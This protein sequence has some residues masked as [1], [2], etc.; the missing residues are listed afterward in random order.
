MTGTKGVVR[1]LTGVEPHVLV[2]KPGEWSAA[3]RSDR[4]EPLDGKPGAD[5]EFGPANQRLVDDWLDAIR[6]DREPACSGA[7][8]AKAVEMAMAVYHAALQQ[9]RVVV[10]LEDRR[11]PL[12]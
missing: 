7:N 3:G 5:G 1:L 8:A 12:M 10:P 6:N 9:K 2:L 11:H 4:W